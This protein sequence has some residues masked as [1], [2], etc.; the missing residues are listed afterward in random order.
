TSLELRSAPVDVWLL[1]HVHKADF[2]PLRDGGPVGDARLHGA[3]DRFGGYLGTISP[4][5]PGG[6]GADGARLLDPGPEGPTAVATAS[7]LPLA[8]L[9]FET[10]ELDV[11]TLSDPHELGPAIAAAVTDARSRSDPSL[12]ALGLRLR[13][14]GRSRIRSELATSL[15]R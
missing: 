10:V 6:E 14:T 3:G 7:H 1:G 2:G 12:R 5:D 9:R 15:A 4:A 11:G 13:L 8:G